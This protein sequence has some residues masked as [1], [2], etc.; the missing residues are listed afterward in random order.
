MGAV[1]NYGYSLKY[2]SRNLQNNY[3]IVMVVV[4]NKGMSL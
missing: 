2:T 4:K 1:K 3:E